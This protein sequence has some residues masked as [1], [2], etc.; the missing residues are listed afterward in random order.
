MSSSTVFDLICIKCIQWHLQN[1]FNIYQLKKATIFF[2][3]WEYTNGRG[4]KD[5][6]QEC[7]AQFLI[8][9]T[10]MYGTLLSETNRK[11]TELLYNQG[12]MKYIHIITKQE[13]CK[14]SQVRTCGLGKKTQ[15]KEENRQKLALG[16]ESFEPQMGITVVGSCLLGS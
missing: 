10:C 2:F 15:G 8:K 9:N 13:E 6:A 16:S 4:D 14:S 7:G 12:C 11:L 1:A 5:G 3:S